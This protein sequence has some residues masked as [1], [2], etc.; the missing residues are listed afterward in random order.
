[1]P[2]TESYDN[3]LQAHE[4]QA[5]FA[6]LDTELQEFIRERAKKYRFTFQELKLVCE[7][8]ADLQMW[9]EAPLAE[10]WV[11]EEAELEG[12]GK[13]SKKQLFAKI[14]AW[15][16]SLR[17]EAKSY[18][19]RKPETPKPVTMQLATHSSDKNIVGRCPVAS[20]ET[21]CCNLYTID[22]VENCGF[23][24]NYCTIQTFYDDKVLFDSK[25]SE[26]LKKL[27]LDPD[28]FYHLG[29]GQSSDSL[30][31]GNQHR[32]LDCLRE[33]AE[34]NPNV[35][36]E[37]KTKSKNVA[38]FLGN[39]VPRNLVLSWSLNT[40]TI[41]ENEEHFTAS[42]DERLA[43][44]R[45]VAGRGIKIAFHFHPMVYYRDWREDYGDLV[46]QVMARFA[47]EE[48]AFVSFG[49]VTFIKPIV[50]AIRE[51]GRPTKMLQ[52][53]LV[54]GPK[55]KLSYPDAIKRE[56]FRHIYRS[57]AP[58]HDKVYMYLCMEK[59]ELWEAT[60]GFVYGSNDEFEADFGA[61]VLGKLNV[62]HRAITQRRRV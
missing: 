48:V 31:W 16:Q 17:R 60:F 2:S 51:R 61:K 52:M 9:G 41:I 56:L 26:K 49:S 30:M 36:L 37:L 55:G 15:L 43:A 14:Q 33:F 54:P 6:R 27:D 19:E 25:L 10:R 1:M 21:V 29:T 11:L 18:P 42:L 39:D 4:S 28:R 35:L 34:D 3:K 20:D 62:T 45:H 40:P 53:E 47:P 44:A 32:H 5:F 46:L 22:A 57:F 23:G 59:A 7:A 38:Y 50:K 12:L 58:W 24:C 13:L 8:A